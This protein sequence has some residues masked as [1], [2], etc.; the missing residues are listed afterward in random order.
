MK[1]FSTTLGVVGG[2]A[3]L[4]IGISLNGSLLGFFDVPSLFITFGGS[5]MALLV[6]YSF[7]QFVTAFK[8]LK[9]AFFPKDVR[10]QELIDAIVGYAKKARRDGILS[11]EDET[12]TL[13][14][15]FLKKGVQ[16]LVDGTDPELVRNI[17]E[18]EIAVMEER[19]KNNKAF[20]DS[21][22]VLAPGFGMIGTVIG[23]IQML[24]HLEDV[25]KIGPA[26][27][28][29][30]ITTLYGAVWANLFC[31]PVAGKLA[32]LSSVEIMIRQMIVEG[33]LS[34][35]AGE[36]PRLIGEKLM[37]FLTPVQRAEFLSQSVGQ[38]RA[39]EV[40]SLG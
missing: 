19:H 6:N 1:N 31:I 28:V 25:S 14:D 20:Y 15:P 4:A 38:G 39:Q 22:A 35:Q 5:I 32:K 7:G 16:L 26:M 3:L 30:L 37:A 18:V 36:N 34:I 17:L 10:P 2:F 29:A 24:G 21:W 9:Q 11:L 12:Q 23:L 8:S 27:A 13:E 40:R 33:I